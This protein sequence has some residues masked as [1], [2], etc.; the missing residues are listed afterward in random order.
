MVLKLTDQTLEK[1]VRGIKKLLRK[2]T[3]I[4]EVQ[5]GFKTR[6]GATGIIFILKQPEEK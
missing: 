3:D 5:F 2:H 4:N 6:Y 1:A